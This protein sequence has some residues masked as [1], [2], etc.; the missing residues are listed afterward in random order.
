MMRRP[1]SVNANLEKESVRPV[2]PFLQRLVV[3]GDRLFQPRGAALPSPACRKRVA[4]VGLRHRP[5]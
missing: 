2:G 5:P 1:A 4:E 3:G